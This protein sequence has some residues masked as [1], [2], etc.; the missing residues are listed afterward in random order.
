MSSAAA[1]GGG[2]GYDQGHREEVIDPALW[3]APGVGASSVGPTPGQSRKSV[4]QQNQEP[5]IP[6]GRRPSKKRSRLDGDDEQGERVRKT[7]QTRECG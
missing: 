6:E 3:S 5:P 1:I 2:Y 7:R 4:Y